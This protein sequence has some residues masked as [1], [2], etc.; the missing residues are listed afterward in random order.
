MFLSVE[1]NHVM[2]MHIEKTA[3]TS[4]RHM[5]AKQYRRDQIM[6]VPLVG[7]KADHRIYP[8]SGEDYPAIL[9]KMNESY[10]NGYKLIMGHYNWSHVQRLSPKWKVF[11]FFRDPAERFISH[12][13]FIRDRAMD[14][15]LHSQLKGVSLESF[16]SSKLARQEFAVKQCLWM[17]GDPEAPLTANSFSQALNNLNKLHTIGIVEQM[18][19]S[20]KLLEF[21]YGYQFDAPLHE[22][23]TPRPESISPV[24]MDEIKFICRHDYVLYDTAKAIFDRMIQERF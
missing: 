24:V 7:G 19:A 14:H 23:R 11:T 13:Y 15:P 4:L 17:S 9:S 16:V 1:N 8:T 2:F 18:D 21:T 12:F 20:L 22:N 10:G 6:P 3:G 5:L